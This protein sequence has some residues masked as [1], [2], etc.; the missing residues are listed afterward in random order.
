MLSINSTDHHPFGIQL[1]P[2]SLDI[3]LIDDFA[4]RVRLRDA[5]KRRYE[6]PITMYGTDKVNKN[7]DS[8]LYD[9]E[10]TRDRFGL[11]VTRKETGTVVFN[12]TIGPLIYADQFLQVSSFIAV[13]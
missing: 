4:I 3:T 10:V 2:V 5:T 12:S 6:V 8:A 13:E 9:L 7:A 1:N 11:L